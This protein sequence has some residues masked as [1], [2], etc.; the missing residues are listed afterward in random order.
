[1]PCTIIYYLAITIR[2]KVFGANAWKNI[3]PIT[4]LIY[5]YIFVQRA[6][7]GEYI[8]N[9]ELLHFE[10]VRYTSIFSSRYHI[11]THISRIRF[12][13]HSIEQQRIRKENVFFLFFFLFFQRKSYSTRQRWLNIQKKKKE[14]KKLVIKQEPFA[15]YYFLAEFCFTNTRRRYDG[16]Y[17]V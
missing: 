2:R 10:S 16:I 14:E 3:K 13:F 7:D 1:M 6:D 11:C 4:N 8:Y 9:K 15:K 12:L 17:I 5:I